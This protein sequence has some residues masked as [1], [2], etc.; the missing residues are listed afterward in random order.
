MKAVTSSSK[1][2]MPL[3][4]KVD[5]SKVVT[6]NT[7]KPTPRHDPSAPNAFVLPRPSAD[8]QKVYN[9][10][11]H[12]V[13]DV[14]VDPFLSSHLRP[15]QREG[16][17]F[18]YECMMGMKEYDG[19][20]AILADEMGLGKS[21]Q[22]ITLAWTLLKQTP[23]F[24]DKPIAKRV[25]V[26]CPAT[27]VKNWQKEFKKWLGDERVA[28][29]VVDQKSNVNDFVHGRAYPVMIIGYEKLRKLQ[30][31][32]K[33]ASFDLIIC[34]EGHR[35]KS[36][37]I[38]TALAI[39]TLP[40]RRRIILSGTPIQNDLSE[41]FA[42]VDFVNP[43]VLGAYNAFKKVFEEPILN[44]RR[45]DATEEEKQLGAMR[46]E[47]LAR[48]T[49]MFVL[50]RTADINQKYLP[51]KMEQVI[52]VKPTRLQL[53]IYK[54]ILE[55]PALNKYLYSRTS[56]SASSGAWSLGLIIALRKLCNSVQLTMNDVA[57]R[58][59]DNESGSDSSDLNSMYQHLL[60]GIDTAKT[61]EF[62]SKIQ[63]LE[64][65]LTEFAQRKEKV[66]LVSHFTQ[67]L[68]ILETLCKSKSWSFLRLDGSTASSKR[69][70]YVDTFNSPS[71]NV[72]VFLLSSKSGGMGLN[73]VAASRL[74][75][76][77][78]DWNPSNDAQAMARIWRD[79]QRR[80]VFIYRLLTTGTIE[81]KIYQRQITKL[82]LSDAIIDNP[83]E[84][85]VNK[86]SIEDLRDIFTL[87]TDTD[88]Y[89]H[90]LL[91]CDCLD[92]A[93]I[94][95]DVSSSD[96]IDALEIM[97]MNTSEDEHEEVEVKPTRKRAA[98]G[99]S[100]ALLPSKAQAES[101]SELNDWT[102][103]RVRRGMKKSALEES[104]LDPVLVDVLG[105]TEN[106]S[107]AFWRKSSDA[108]T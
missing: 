24:G 26:V 55:T 5:Q 45:T 27:L 61:T 93:G 77:D 82:S 85:S 62:S 81:E 10:K 106:V 46:N 25:L 70:E 74:V 14:V 3:V 11:K 69:G 101:F 8:H 23:Y 39:K 52:F 91:G 13:I 90:H 16:V 99:K 104:I 108:S 32:L 20:G 95:S 100:K 28:T 94:V 68:D 96:D 65:L 58:S 75:L 44:S 21:V 40:T 97:D 72:F 17:Q 48:L 41:Y 89:T 76:F 1:F 86:F 2:K 33:H 53:A 38:K 49:K 56:S 43:G 6:D 78:I 92:N 60:D 47:E 105:K 19:C 22:A 57:A 30:E 64:S 63:V 50:R 67:T 18:L 15:H 42:M 4:G 59:T 35:L 12:P 87:H 29:F 102:H 107:F 71:S 73:L 31:I 37:Q 88:C 51:P 84:A 54:R 66:V 34:D 83:S 9:S 79:G 80:Q 98:N 7:A 36:P 103:V